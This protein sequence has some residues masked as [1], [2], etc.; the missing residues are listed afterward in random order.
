MRRLSAS[1]LLISI[2][3]IAPAFAYTAE[4]VSAC[5]PDVMR[6]CSDA[7]PDEGRITKCMIKKQKQV[8]V[9]CMMAFKKGAAISRVAAK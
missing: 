5:T 7:I 9:A 8:S 4:Q 6:L 1:A 3:M 2:V